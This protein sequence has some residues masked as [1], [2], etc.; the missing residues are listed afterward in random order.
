M[1]RALADV[2]LALLSLSVM[3]GL[4][5]VIAFPDIPEHVY[6]WVIA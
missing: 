1:M 2:G 4:M 6:Q 5:A 3:A